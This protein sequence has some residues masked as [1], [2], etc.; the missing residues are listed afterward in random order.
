MEDCE[1]FSYRLVGGGA[2]TF[3][4]FTPPFSSSSDGRPQAAASAASG[5]L[6]AARSDGEWSHAQAALMESPLRRHLA[7]ALTDVEGL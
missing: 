4:L 7:G 6:A 1:A 5:A 2:D 3:S